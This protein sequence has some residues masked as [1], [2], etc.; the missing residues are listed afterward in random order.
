MRAHELAVGRTFAVVFE[1]G[2][3]FFTTLSEF[4]NTNGIRQ[5]YLPMFVAGFSS[6]D[7]VGTCEAL[8]DPKAPVW[9]KVHLKNVEAFGCGTLARDPHTDD[10]LPHIHTSL[11]LKEH[12]ATAHTSHLLAATV[13]FLV[14]MVIIEVTGPSMTRERDRQLYDVP[15]LNFGR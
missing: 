9:T 13:Q 3:D 14:E 6:A 10:L 5:G 15:L 2:E 8:P 7:V 1:H 4:C 11:G 12:S